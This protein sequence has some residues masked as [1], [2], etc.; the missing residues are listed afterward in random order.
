MPQS[1]L[2]RVVVGSRNPNRIDRGLFP[3][4]VDIR[5]QKEAVDSAERVVFAAVYPE[6]YYTLVGSATRLNSGEQS[7]AEKLAELFPESRVVKGFNVISAWALQAGVHDGSRQVLICSDCST[8]K[9][10]VLQLARSM[11]FSPM[12]VGGLCQSR[13][14]E[15]AP[16]I[17]FPSWG[18]QNNFHQLPLVTMNETLPA[19][20]L[21]TLALV[22][23]PGLVAAVF[24][25]CRGTKYKRFPR[26]LDHW[27]CRRK[28]LGL[29]SFLCVVLHA[30]Y[31]MCLTLR[32]AAG[33]TLLNAAYHQVKADV[34]NSSVGQQ[35]WRSDL[36]LSCGILGFGV[37]TLLAITSLPSVGNAF[38]WREFTFV[39]SGLGYTALTLSIMHTLF[40]GWDF[41]FFPVAYPYY[42]PPMYLLAL[43]LPCIVL[44][45]WV[46]IAQFYISCFLYC[47]YLIKA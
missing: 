3:D 42:L 8:S 23:L 26:W 13:D 32:R 40:F 17:L 36:Y 30:V 9:D 20:A 2:P 15:E 35:V 1:P 31:S 12:D 38:N 10:T 47:Q 27:L 43:I 46:V 34:E 45:P 5:S 16:L 33:Y 25:L 29:L 21:V 6:H 4:G 22:Y 39:Q 7:N 44:G 14:I 11:G 19:V 37:L 28:Q 24:Q 41:A 18:G